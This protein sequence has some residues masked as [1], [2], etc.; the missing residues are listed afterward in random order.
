MCKRCASIS[1]VMYTMY[2]RY[3]TFKGTLSKNLI[4]INNLSKK[5]I[6]H[7]VVDSIYTY[8]RLER[9]YM[10]PLTFFKKVISKTSTLLTSCIHESYLFFTEWKYLAPHASDYSDFGCVLHT[11]WVIYDYGLYFK[12]GNNLW[13]YYR[14]Y[15][16]G[17]DYV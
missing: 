3:T 17:G 7:Y 5:A 10:Y 11:H 9:V 15:D 16:R 8:S 13:F 1:E 6:T 4:S 14:C 12:D 2:T